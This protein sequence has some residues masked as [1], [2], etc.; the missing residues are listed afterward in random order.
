MK[1]QQPELLQ[2][3]GC[4]LEPWDD[5]AE[6]EDE[7]LRHTFSPP[8]C[9]IVLHPAPEDPAILASRK[10]AQEDE[11]RLHPLLA[12]TR[13]ASAAIGSA[14]V[15]LNGAAL[16]LAPKEAGDAQ[17]SSCERPSSPRTAPG[18]A[19]PQE[20]TCSSSRVNEHAPTSA[21][22]RAD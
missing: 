12:L 20:D 4:D 2:Q 11:D 5:Q 14:G 21:Q 13:Q 15:I 16:E 22:P 8:G 10:A 6:F 3:D 7:I 18:R 19:I 1:A 9:P 17:S